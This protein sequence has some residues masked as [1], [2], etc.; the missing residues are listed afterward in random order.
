MYETKKKFSY[1][2]FVTEYEFLSG[3]ING[4]LT[5]SSFEDATHATILMVNGTK[6]ETFPLTSGLGVWYVENVFNPK[7]I[8]RKLKP[9]NDYINP[10]RTVYIIDYDEHTLDVLLSSAKKSLAA[11][12]KKKANKKAEAEKKKADDSKN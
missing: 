7:K 3:E 4:K 5:P 11:F 2:G 1:R 12:E 8:T 10:K 9:L 6:Q